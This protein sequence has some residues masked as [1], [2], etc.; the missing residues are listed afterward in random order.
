MNFFKQL[1]RREPTSTPGS[2][3][4]A[5]GLPSEDLFLDTQA[6]V[7]S[8]AAS[9]ASLLGS[10]LGRDFMSLG[11]EEGFDFHSAEY[12]KASRRR[13]RAEFL[14]LLDQVIL[15]RRDACRLVQ[16]RMIELEDLSLEMHRQLELQLE[17]MHRVLHVLEQQKTL[18]ANEEGWLM[19]ALHA[20]QVGYHRG[21]QDRLDSDE[22]IQGQRL[23]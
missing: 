9:E 11:Q 5:P 2:E 19:Q 17:E 23:F 7:P 4:I 15:E 10:F 18:A 1:F 16:H 13:I 21:V 12:L 3:A 14:V 20:Y 6:P 22:F 8:P